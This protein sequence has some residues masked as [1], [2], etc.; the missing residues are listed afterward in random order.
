MKPATPAWKKIVCPVCKALPGQ[1][2][3]MGRG[4]LSMAHSERLEAV[5]QIKN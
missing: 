3:M 4:A 1:N 2:C 5:N